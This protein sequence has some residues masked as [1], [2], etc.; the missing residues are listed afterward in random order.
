MTT[1]ATHDQT[2]CL[3]CENLAQDYSSFCLDCDGGNV[4]RPPAKAWVRCV[5][6]HTAEAIPGRNVCESCAA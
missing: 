3:T 1:T 5:R 6:C 2:Q 4:A